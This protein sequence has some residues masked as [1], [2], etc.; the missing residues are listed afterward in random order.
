MKKIDISYGAYAA[1]WGLTDF[2]EESEK[3]LREAIASGEP[4]ETE[5][6]CKKEIRYATIRRNE[7]GDIEVFAVAHMDDLFDGCDLIYDALWSRFR[8]EE[9][10][11]DDMIEVIIDAAI[12]DGIDDH[13]QL[14]AVLDSSATFEDVC[15]MIS[16]LESEAEEAN[17]NM[18]N[19]L[20]DILQGLY[21][22]RIGGV[23]N[24]V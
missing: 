1:K 7:D 23:D 21:E 8:S 24:D 13:T 22:G 5:Y 17:K 19:R 12:D 11:P 9:E 14:S 4:F 2:Y 20:C 16:S 6:G 18:F 10:L 15:E 3:A